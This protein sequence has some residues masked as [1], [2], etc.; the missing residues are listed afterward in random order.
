LSNCVVPFERKKEPNLLVILDKD[1]GKMEYVL[2]D[3]K[4]N[5]N[6]LNLTTAPYF[7][8]L[9]LDFLGESENQFIYMSGSEK[10]ERMYYSCSKVSSNTLSEHLN[11]THEEVVNNSIS[12]PHSSSFVDLNGD[13]IP[14]IILTSYNETKKTFYIEYWLFIEKGKYELY[15]YTEIQN[16]TS[17]KEISQLVFADF[18]ITRLTS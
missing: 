11:N 14:D 18:G 17:P 6:T 1:N 4:G 16:V 13:C 3:L 15:G 5:N 9:V 2:M 7:Q 12:V 8:P 10:P